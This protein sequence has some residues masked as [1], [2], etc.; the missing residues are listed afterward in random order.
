MFPPLSLIIVFIHFRTILTQ[1][2]KISVHGVPLLG[3]M[4]ESL[5]IS[6]YS[7]TIDKV[8]NIIE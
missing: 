3:G 7:G 8:S 5:L 1:T 4:L 6:A 2:A